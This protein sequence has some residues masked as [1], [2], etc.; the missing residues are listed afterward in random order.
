MEGDVCL[1]SFDLEHGGEYCGVVQLSAE[2]ISLEISEAPNGS[3][4]GD[5]LESAVK[6]PTNFNEYVNL[7]E[8]VIWDDYCT[9]IH[10][11]RA[12]DDCIKNAYGICLV[13][14]GFLDWFRTHTAQYSAVILVAWN[15]ETCDL[16]WLWKITQAPRSMYNA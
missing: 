2:L 1:L 3:V 14:A 6:N 11:L 7:G 4:T 13:W 10:G 9:A 5:K 16:K 15:G 8:G 12:T